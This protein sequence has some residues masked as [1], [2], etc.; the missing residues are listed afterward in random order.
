[1]RVISERSRLA[2]S[3]GAG[4]STSQP[5]SGPYSD[6][7]QP[8]CQASAFCRSAGGSPAAVPAWARS[9]RCC[10]SGLIISI[11]MLPCG[12]RSARPCASHNSRAWWSGLSC[13]SPTS[14]R[15]A[16]ARRSS[17]CAGVSSA[18]LRRSRIT[19]RSA[20]S[21][22][23]GLCHSGSGGALE[24]EMLWQAARN[25]TEASARRRMGIP[26]SG[27]RSADDRARDDVGRERPDRKL[28]AEV[29]DAG[30]RP[31][32]RAGAD[33]RRAA[34]TAGRSSVPPG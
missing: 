13:C 10:W 22:P 1:M 7:S 27:R 26:F 21:R 20:L 6:Q 23:S 16:P 8:F 11:R 12:R 32:D 2:D 19:P 31:D 15:G 3:S 17:S 5:T 33:D 25:S 34:A 18:P 9:T 28:H 29:P 14:T 24:G 30:P 4:C